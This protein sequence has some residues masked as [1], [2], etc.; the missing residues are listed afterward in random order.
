L[1][2]LGLGIPHRRIQKLGEN[3]TDP[4][5]H[6]NG[7]QGVNERIVLTSFFAAGTEFPVCLLASD[8]EGSFKI[9]LSSRGVPLIHDGLPLRKSTSSSILAGVL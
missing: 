9:I 2:L 8:C 5:N 4:R 6:L 3:I 1:R 7:R